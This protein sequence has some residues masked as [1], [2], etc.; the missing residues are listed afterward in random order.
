MMLVLEPYRA[1][2][3]PTMSLPDILFKSPSGQ[4]ANIEPIVKFVSMIDE[5]SRGSKVTMNL[6]LSSS[7]VMYERS[8]ESPDLTMPVS[9]RA[10]KIKESV[11]TS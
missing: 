10:P 7:C 3:P 8:S 9:L 2:A 5:P 6:P 1:N 4:I 11:C